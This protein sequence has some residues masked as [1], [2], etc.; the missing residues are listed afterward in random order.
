M[1][2]PPLRTEFEGESVL[3]VGVQNGKAGEWDVSDSLDELHQ[4]SLTSGAR[5]L[6]RFICRQTKPYPSHYV[7]K[8]KVRE[9]AEWAAEHR[10]SSLVFDEDLSPAQGRNLEEEIGV[11]VIDRTQMILDIFAQH[12]H[13]K[14]GRLQIELA[15]LEYLLPRLRRM[16]THL[17][18]QKGGIGLRGPGE[19]QLETDRRRIEERI[20][21]L[22]K[23]LDQVRRHRHELRRGRRRHG[24]ALASLV[25]Y[26]NA[27]KSTLLN[28]LTGSNVE[29][30]N[31]L[32][33][34]L[35]PTTRQVELPNQQSVL[36]TDTVGFIRKLPHH[37]VE[38]FKATLE[39]VVEADLLIH[40]IDASH[41]R[42]ESQIEAVREVLKEIG[43]V[44]GPVLHVLNK[45]DAEEGR[46]QWPRLAEE[47][48][49]A[50]PV[51]ARTGEG[52][53]AFLHEL[54]DRLRD[55]NVRLDL[56]IPMSKG[57]LIAALHRVGDVREESYEAAH[58]FLTAY[59]PA[60]MASRFEPYRDGGQDRESTSGSTE[61][62]DKA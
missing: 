35:D 61:E 50:V 18:R 45:I 51:S 8:G 27:G 55:R 20:S 22:K 7:G 54:A 36:L 25:G 56:C 53:E 6:G 49:R 38:S 44:E 47:L 16:W 40:I 4:L 2:R 32:F 59:V 19:K 21:R 30:Y 23:E 39:E 12:A 43:V 5:V 26:T 60:H 48:G 31:Q 37:L 24:W 42:V 41:P 9:I 1:D 33:S 62:P 14:E 57:D 13:T 17:E 52:V 46:R 29:A 28:A 10:P 11:K 34:T 15:Q 3:L 58:A